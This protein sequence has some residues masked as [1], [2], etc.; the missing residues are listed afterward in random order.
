M[1]RI[2][3]AVRESKETQVA[4][5][6]NLDGRGKADC[7]S[8]IG[9][10]DHMLALLAAHGGFDLDIQAK[11]DLHCLGQSLSACLGQ[12]KEHTKIRYG[13]CPHG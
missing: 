1:N 12:Q 7:T 11:G 5:K 8:G 2:G 13:F 10:F 3:E 6:I 4:V 9:F